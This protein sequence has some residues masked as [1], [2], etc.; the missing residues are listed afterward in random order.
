LQQQEIIEFKVAMD[1]NASPKLE[2]ET[3]LELKPESQVSKK[4]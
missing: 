3:S 1:S 2:S 4:R